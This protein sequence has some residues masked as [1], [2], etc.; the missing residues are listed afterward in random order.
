MRFTLIQ[1]LMYR[2]CDIKKLKI[3]FHSENNRIN[4]LRC[5][6]KLYGETMPISEKHAKSSEAGIIRNIIT[7][8]GSGTC[9]SDRKLEEVFACLTR[10]EERIDMLE[11]QMKRHFGNSKLVE[12]EINRLV[13]DRWDSLSRETDECLTRMMGEMQDLRDIVIGLRSSVRGMEK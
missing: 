5:R 8:G 12:A 4:P 11:A 2:K 1:V 13:S 6:K 3:K 10:L 7:K 9:N